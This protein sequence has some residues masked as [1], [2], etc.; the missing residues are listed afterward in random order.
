MAI[1]TERKFT[2]TGN[3]GKDI[4][5]SKRITQGYICADQ[6]R[7]VRVRIAGDDAFL[8]IKG[9]SDERFWSRYEFEQQ[10]PLADGEELMKLC[11]S[12]II[13]KVR[14]YVPVGNH[15]WEV[16][17]F[18][19]DNEGL[20]IAEIEL[21]SE[22]ETVEIPS[23]VGIEVTTDKRYYNSM[24]SKTPYSQWKENV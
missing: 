14:H 13:D 12:G 3:F 1:E 24:L 22:H 8:T 11:I 20:I 18:H 23:W 6:G 16:D 4:K 21:E 9:P 2:V 10:I 17:I 7:T 5:S 15:V 19:G